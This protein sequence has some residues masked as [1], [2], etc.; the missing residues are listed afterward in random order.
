MQSLRQ[1][2]RIKNGTY[3]NCSV[4]LIFSA[5]PPRRSVDAMIATPGPAG[6][7]TSMPLLCISSRTRA[8]PCAGGG[9]AIVGPSA[10]AAAIVGNILCIAASR[11]ARAFSTALQQQAAR[12]KNVKC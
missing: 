5:A 11:F 10:A 8:F 6:S 1:P 4:S 7:G 2:L 3:L 12:E 9:G